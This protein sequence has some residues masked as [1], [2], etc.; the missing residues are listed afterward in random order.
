MKYFF[1]IIYYLNLFMFLS[2]S[3]KSKLCID[4]KFFKN[5]LF[6]KNFGKCLLFEKTENYDDFLVDGKKRNKKI[7][8]Y[9]CSIARQFDDMCGKDGKLYEPKIKRNYFRL[10]QNHTSLK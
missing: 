7:D 3:T 9:Y 6:G 2:K 8:Y 1:I 10:L 5:D 4:C